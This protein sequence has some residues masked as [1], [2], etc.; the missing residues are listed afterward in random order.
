[1]LAAALARVAGGA[2][3]RERLGAAGLDAVRAFDRDAWASG[4][5]R[6]LATLG[7]SEGVGSVA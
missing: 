4:F 6:A 5:S 7:L 3:L 2:A 1:M